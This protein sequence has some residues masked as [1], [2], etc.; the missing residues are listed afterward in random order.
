MQKAG[1]LQRSMQTKPLDLRLWPPP[2]CAPSGNQEGERIRV[3]Q[4][5]GVSSFDL[6][7]FGLGYR[8]IGIQAFDDSA[9]KHLVLFG[10]GRAMCVKA[11]RQTIGGCTAAG[12]VQSG[13][14]KGSLSDVY[15]A[16]EIIS[17]TMF[18]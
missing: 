14:T 16:I 9:T 1:A 3:L 18:E 17:R 5:D 4:D 10:L 13:W 15:V 2:A 7:S 12:E 8:N 11:R 6:P